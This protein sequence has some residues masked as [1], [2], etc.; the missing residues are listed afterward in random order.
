MIRH[1]SNVRLDVSPGEERYDRPALKLPGPHFDAAS[2]EKVIE[3]LG[4]ANRTLNDRSA[5]HEVVGRVIWEICGVLHVRRRTLRKAEWLEFVS[6][7]RKQPIFET[8]QQDAFT[9]RAFSKPSGY[10]GDAQLLDYMYGTEH[11]W[12]APEMNWVGDRIFRWSTLCSA[13]EGVKSRRAIIADQIDE[14]AKQKKKP[15]IMSLACGH[16]REAEISSAIIRRQLGR[17]V[18][19]DSD[20][21]SLITVARDYG[22]YGVETVHTNARELL[23][24]RIQTGSFDLIYSSGL[25]DYLSDSMCQNLARNLFDRLKPG[26]RLLLTNFVENVEAVGYMETFMDWNLIYRDR[27][28][29]MQMLNLIP[30]RD[31]KQVTV[32]SEEN[33]NVLFALVERIG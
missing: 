13:C 4:Q 23:L 22:K 3:Y 25:C 26:G 30:N 9:H 27:I 15:D 18:A 19:I 14:L 32:Y 10:A 16:F 7:L 8:L 12:P 5:T 17:I 6:R 29:M 33:N 1:R 21:D 20:Q 31:V 28:D 24:G 2:S 11:F